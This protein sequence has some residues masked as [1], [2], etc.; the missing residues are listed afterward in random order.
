MAENTKFS[1]FIEVEIFPQN[2]S[3]D[4]KTSL[5]TQLLLPTTYVGTRGGNVFIGVCSRGRGLD[6]SGP[7]SVWAGPVRV[8]GCIPQPSDPSPS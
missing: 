4:I 6:T 3:H 8:M 7:V 1:R 5:V 2:N